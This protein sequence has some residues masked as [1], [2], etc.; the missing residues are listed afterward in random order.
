VAQ[1]QARRPGAHHAAG[2]R[3]PGDRELNVADISTADILKVIEP[4]WISKTETASRVRGRIEAVLGWAT[5]RGYRGGD[6]P[7]RWRGHL[8]EALPKRGKV[9]KVEHHAAL[10][11]REIPSFMA[12][13]RQR[14]GMAAR[15]LEF[16]ILA[17]ARTGE[18]I[19]C[20]WNEL[21]L[22]AR[23]W[24]VPPGRMKA[25]RKHTVTLSAA[26]VELLNG[27]PREGDEDDGFVFIGARPGTALSITGMAALLK[28]MGRGNVTIHG[29]RSTF[30]DW[31]AE[32]TNFPREVAE[33][34][35]AHTIGDKVEAA[36]RRGDLRRK[37]FQVAE[38]WAR[39]CQSVP[40]EKTGNK[41]VQIRAS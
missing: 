29:F 40:V 3:L 1:P 39:Y 28:R 35:L 13:L 23:L 21:D 11:W 18:V 2:L 32:C 38:S 14:E 37:R 41:V 9:A 10:P 36:Y 34:A 6:N 4:I 33:M 15:A 26:A 31:S 30:R 22:A 20:R 8:S 24:E 5:V 27:L 7:A 19:G 16:C 25:G 17:C 12:E